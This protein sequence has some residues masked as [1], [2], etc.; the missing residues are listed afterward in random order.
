DGHDEAV[1]GADDGWIYAINLADENGGANTASLEWAL[2]V[3]APVST[4]AAGDVDRDG[5]QELLVSTAAG[6]G[7]VL[8]SLG[9]AL[10]IINPDGSCF[11]VGTVDVDGI[12]YGV[13]IVD[14]LLNGVLVDS[15]DVGEGGM[16]T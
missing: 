6:Q 11:E 16:W 7:I 5:F 3:G 1:L 12:A 13:A 14:L 8:D 15:V 9:V 2:E 10:D 4:L